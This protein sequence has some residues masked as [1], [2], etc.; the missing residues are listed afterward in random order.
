MM[1]FYTW[2]NLT[3]ARRRAEG[4]PAGLRRRIALLLAL[5]IGLALVPFAGSLHAQPEGDSVLTLIVGEKTHVLTHEDLRKLPE[6]SFSTTTIWTSGLQQ[7]RGIHLRDLIKTYLPD[8]T[9]LTLIAAN[10]Y[11]ITVPVED[12]ALDG[13]VLAYERNGSV[14]TLRDKGPL[15]LVYPYDLKL[16]FQNEIIYSNSIWQLERIIVKI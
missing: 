16:K 10:D 13:A 12:L 6:T 2:S 9:E 3:G 7:F 4:P 5:V 14:M 15:W 8:A 11:Q 1:L